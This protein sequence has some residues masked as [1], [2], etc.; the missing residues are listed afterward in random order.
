MLCGKKEDV[1]THTLPIHNPYIT[2]MPLQENAEGEWRS[3]EPKTIPVN[4][5][6]RPKTGTVCVPKLGRYRAQYCD[7]NGPKYGPGTVSNMSPIRA[8]I[9]D[10]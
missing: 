10:Y 8:H 5:P 2:Q 3:T 9:W 6:H 1:I 7:P 4:D